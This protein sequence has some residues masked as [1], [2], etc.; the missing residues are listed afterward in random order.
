MTNFE[1]GLYADP[2]ADLDTLWWDLVE[3]YQLVHRPDG[4]HAPDWAAKIHLAAAPVYYQ[5]YLYGE[6]FASQLDA[7]LARPRRRP[8]RPRRGR[9]APRAT[10]C[11]RPAR[12]CGG[13][14][15]SSAPPASRSPPTHLARELDRGERLTWTSGC[16][17]GPRS[18]RAAPAAWD[19]PPPTC[20]RAE[21]CRVAVLARTPSD[22]REAEEELLAAGPRTPSGCECDLLDTGEVEAAFTFLD[23]RWGECHVL[24]NTVGPAHVGGLDD[25]T[26]DAWLDE[27]DLGVLTMIRTTRAALPLLRKATFAR[28]VNVAASS[29]RH[30]SPGLIGFTAAKA[31][32]ASASKN[33][34]RA[35]APEGIIVNTVAPGTVMSPTLAS[36]LVGTDLEGLPEGPLEAAYEAIARDYGA[37]NDIGRVGLPE[38]VATDGR[39]PL[40]RAL[41]LRGGRDHRRRRRHRLLLTPSSGDDPGGTAR[42]VQPRRPV[43]AGRRRVPDREALVCGDRRLTYAEV[44]ERA[45][46]LAHHLAGRRRRARRPRRLYLYNGTEYLEAM[47]AAFKLRA[48]PINVNYRYVEDELRYLLDD[49]RRASPSCSTASS[50]RSSPRSA[51][52]LPAARAR[53]SRSTT[54]PARDRRGARRGRTTRP[55][56]PPRRPA[57]DFGP[58]S[59]DD[60]YILYTGGTTGHAQGR[61][62]APRGHLLRRARRR[63]ASA[64]RRSRRPRRSPS[65]ARPRTGACLPACPFMHG[66]A[67]WMAFGTLFTRRHRRHP[68]RASPRPARALAS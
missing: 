60:L 65:A 53:S 28:V 58:R 32:M 45:N 43:G 54:A 1:R 31:A 12:R 30:Q 49:C 67:H 55:R 38:E 19:A 29:I 39:L 44:D 62:V 7:T 46:R 11:S 41:Q 24:V 20:S 17:D 37:S 5:N 40:L 6:L 3:R 9:R 27:F 35:L 57:R 4:R 47:L 36:Y 33:L 34:S 66:T 48:V 18:S 63:R 21:G 68:A 56:S 59:A 2:D 13:T 52:T 25:L 15:S 14:R 23:E 22:L 51:P 26:D 64:T 61:D 10:T 16:A 42:G 50:R 8:R